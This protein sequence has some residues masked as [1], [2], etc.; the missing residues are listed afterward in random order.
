[1]STQVPTRTQSAI[2][3]LV[4]IVKTVILYIAS[5]QNKHTNK[6]FHD[7]MPIYII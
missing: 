3:Q 2:Q 7:A 4:L 6:T 1:M 5:I